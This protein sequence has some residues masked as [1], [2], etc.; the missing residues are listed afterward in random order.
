M[1]TLSK[2]YLSLND[3]SSS[4]IN[5]LASATD[6]VAN[7]TESNFLTTEKVVLKNLAEK[8]RKLTRQADE[9]LKQTLKVRGMDPNKNL[10][11]RKRAADLEQAAKNETGIK[12]GSYLYFPGGHWVPLNCKAK[13]KVCTL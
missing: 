8:A 5:S 13:W 6:Y 1:N 10:Y 11:N 2:H 4:S 3:F 12:I 9:R 7:I